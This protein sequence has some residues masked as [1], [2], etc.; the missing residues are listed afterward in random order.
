MTACRP[1]LRSYAHL[2][3]LLHCGRLKIGRRDGSYNGLRHFCE[4]NDLWQAVEW[5]SNR[6]QTVTVTDA[7]SPVDTWRQISPTFVADE[8]KASSTFVDDILPKCRPKLFDGR[9]LIIACVTRS[10]TPLAW[11]A[12]IRCILIDM[13]SIKCFVG[14]KCRKMWTAGYSYTTTAAAE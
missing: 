4:R 14:S 7:L 2:C 12:P 10:A 3:G 9:K 6:S 13:S 5:P 11:H 8:I 1:T